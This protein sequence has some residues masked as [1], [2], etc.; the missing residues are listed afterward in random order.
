V[1]MKCV[2]VVSVCECMCVVCVYPVVRPD[3]MSAQI[4]FLCV[5]VCEC[6]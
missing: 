1:S 2:N 5:Y 4:V 6:V 3:L